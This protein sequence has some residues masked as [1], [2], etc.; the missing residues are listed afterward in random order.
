MNKRKASHFS[1]FRFAFL[2][3]RNKKM[4]GNNDERKKS[5]ESQ[6][7]RKMPSRFPTPG[8]DDT[9]CSY[10]GCLLGVIIVICISTIATGASMLQAENTRDQ[11]IQRYIAAIQQFG[12]STLHVLTRTNGTIATSIG[13]RALRARVIPVNYSQD[14]PDPE[15]LPKN[16][17]SFALEAS[18]IQVAQS[19]P[20]TVA[21]SLFETSNSSSS[22]STTEPSSSS[23]QS[24]SSFSFPPK[25]FNIVLPARV[26]ETTVRCLTRRS[27][28]DADLQSQCNGVFKWSVY[29][30]CVRDQKCGTCTS[31][32]TS[33]CKSITY[34]GNEHGWNASVSPGDDTSGL[35]GC[36]GVG[37]GFEYSDDAV[38]LST[39]INVRL[40]ASDDPSAQ[41]FKITNGGNQFGIRH[42]VRMSVGTIMVAVGS[43]ILFC[44]CAPLV[45]MVAYTS[46]SCKRSCAGLDDDDNGRD[47]SSTAHGENGSRLGAAT[48]QAI[49]IVAAGRRRTA[50]VDEDDEGEEMSE[51][52]HNNNSSG[53]ASIS[54]LTHYYNSRAAWATMPHYHHRHFQFGM[55]SPG[56]SMPVALFNNAA[57]PVAEIHEFPNAVPGT[58]VLGTP[59]TALNDGGGSFYPAATTI[60]GADTVQQGTIFGERIQQGREQQQQQQEEQQ[61]PSGYIFVNQVANDGS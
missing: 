16:V 1:C 26:R 34:H 8:G 22:L 47:D 30:P 18:S 9:G 10:C 23:P 3:L 48:R 14:D 57:V 28:F 59:V 32:L 61:R 39:T 43:S 55:I 40:L 36:G 35:V 24:V 19:I 27:C 20:T 54:N 50:N 15:S 2:S 4:N 53:G 7:A 46:E 51:Q 29:P 21:V 52:Q 58:V 6:G 44:V 5:T 11:G 41:L 45:F 56:S 17:T 33:V 38:V 60:G 25:T 12:D 42:D 49:I 31:Y 13:T 37:A